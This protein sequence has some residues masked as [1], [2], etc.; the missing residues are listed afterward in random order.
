LEKD[1][2]RSPL[3]FQDIESGR[4]LKGLIKKGLLE[5]EGVKK[6]S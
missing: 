6:G 2:W 1:I 4:I 5:G 3:V